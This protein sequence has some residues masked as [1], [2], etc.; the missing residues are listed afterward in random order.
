[1]IVVENL[2]VA[3]DSIEIKDFNIRVCWW[4]KEFEVTKYLCKSHRFP[5]LEEA[6]KY[7]LED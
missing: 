5:T 1:M 7:C 3:D 4:D 2:F 6:I